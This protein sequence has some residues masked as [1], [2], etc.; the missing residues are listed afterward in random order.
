[1]SETLKGVHVTITPEAW[2]KLI[3]LYD[4]EG[5]GYQFQYAG[6]CRYELWVDGHDTVHG[7]TLH[8][9]GTWTPFSWV[10]A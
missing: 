6:K 9:G 4:A 3:D 5:V 10:E 2:Q 1:M 7:F 8:S